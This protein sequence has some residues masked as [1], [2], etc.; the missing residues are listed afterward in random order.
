MNLENIF[1]IIDSRDIFDELYHF[2][3]SKPIDQKK[4][5]IT[6][7]ISEINYLVDFFTKQ[8]NSTMIISNLNIPTDSSYGISEQKSDY[9]LSDM[10]QQF[11]STLNLNYE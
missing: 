1:L 6:E 10:I 9:G 2:P 8:C 3:Y 7:K 5:W 11:N 4:L